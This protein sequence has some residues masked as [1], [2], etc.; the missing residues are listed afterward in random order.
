MNLPELTTITGWGLTKSVNA[1]VLKP[2]N[3]T[4]L[5]QCIVTAKTHSLE[6][7]I[8]GGGNSYTDTFMNSNQ[9]LIDTSNLKSI[10]HFDMEKG[11]VIVESGIRIGEL[12]EKILVKNWC[13]VGLSGSVNDRVGGMISSNTHGKDS[14]SQ[15]NFIQNIISLKLLIADGTIIEIDRNSD[16]ELFNGVV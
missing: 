11:I 8:R 5:Q 12:L 14:W 6:I 15:G 1:Y 16:S 2:K 4:E 9:L 13:L 7:A 10:K 3:I